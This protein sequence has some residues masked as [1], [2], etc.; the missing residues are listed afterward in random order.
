M[1]HREGEAT[2]YRTVAIASLVLLTCSLWAF[3]GVHLALVLGIQL[4]AFAAFVSEMVIT[5]V[6]ILAA[7]FSLIQDVAV[8]RKDR[9]EATSEYMGMQLMPQY[10]WRMLT[11]MVSCV[12]LWAAAL[13]TMG[14]FFEFSSGRTLPQ[15]AGFTFSS[16]RDTTELNWDYN[17][18]E[19]ALTTRFF[20]TNLVVWFVDLFLGAGTFYIFL[21]YSLLAYAPVSNAQINGWRASKGNKGI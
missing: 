12:L 3:S 13:T 18:A 19:G 10:R 20:A 4:S 6:F 14:T 17:T 9:E 8:R 1:P 21:M 2:A 15:P 7:W 5:T 16:A 11:W